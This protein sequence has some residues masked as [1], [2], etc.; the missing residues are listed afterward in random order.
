MIAVTSTT[1][2]GDSEDVGSLGATGAG[3]TGVD[4]TT[5][6]SEGVITSI[7]WPTE[8]GLEG[9]FGWTEATEVETSG[10]MYIV[11]IGGKRSSEERASVDR[12]HGGMAAGGLVGGLWAGEA[13]AVGSVTGGTGPKAVGGAIGGILGCIEMYLDV[14]SGVQNPVDDGGD[15]S[16]ER[17]RGSSSSLCSEESSVSVD[18]G[19]ADESGR[20]SPAVTK[21]GVG[22]NG[23]DG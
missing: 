16:S 8:E 20:T 13:E 7:F 19:E 4:W 10:L 17:I 1:G 18:H 12:A 11:A 5:V 15:V 6:M 23:I 22:P 9:L 3:G 14:I 21:I 2:A